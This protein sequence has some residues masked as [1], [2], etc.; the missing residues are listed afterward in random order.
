MKVVVIGGTGH[1]GTY[2]IPKLVAK[3][4]EVICVSRSIAKPYVLSPLWDEVQFVSL[5]RTALEKEG[6]FGEKIKAFNAEIVIDLICFELESAISLVETL[7]GHVDHF[8]HCGTV[9]VYGENE[10][11]PSVETQKRNPLI[12]YG[13]K[14]A[15]IEAYLFEFYKKEKFPLTIIH[16]GHI[17]GEGWWPLNPKGNFNPQ[18]FKDLAK[19]AEIQIPNFGLETVHHVHASDV[20][21]GFINA[22]DYKENALGECFNIVSEQGMSLKRYAMAISDWYKQTPNLKFVAWDKWKQVHSEEDIEETLFHV[23]HSTLSSLQK[24][25]NRIGYRP[26]YTSLEAIKESLEFFKN[27]II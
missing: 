5:D 12:P 27:E 18:V 2:L 26:K 7:N 15:Q 9:W 21:S 13:I 11:V 16:P 24:A 3:G 19:G 1:I 4:F 6:T 23:S 8:L 17:V 25:N 22:I 20:A 14:K 10:I